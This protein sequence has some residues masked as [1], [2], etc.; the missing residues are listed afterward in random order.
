LLTALQVDKV[1]PLPLNNAA[2]EAINTA[3]PGWVTAQNTTESPIVIADCSSQAG[4]TSGML[5]DGVH[6]NAQGDQLMA[7]QIGPLLIQFIKDKLAG[8]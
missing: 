2:I 1:I 6:P 8:N 5:R 4:F 7:K 3:I